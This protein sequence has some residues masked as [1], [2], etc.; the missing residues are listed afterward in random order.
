MQTKP[1]GHCAISS[2]Q[3]E[4]WELIYLATIE[5]CRGIMVA[6]L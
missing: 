6:G 3:S 1:W 5:D 2:Q 4:V